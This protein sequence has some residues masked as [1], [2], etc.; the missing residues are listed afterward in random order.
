MRDRDEDRDRLTDGQ[1]DRQGWREK[2]RQ[3]DRQTD[4]QGW[5]EK[6]RGR[7]SILKADSDR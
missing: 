5:R 7:D 4:R 1:A 2:D 6:E 3:T